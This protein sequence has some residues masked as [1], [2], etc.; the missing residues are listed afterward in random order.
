MFEIKVTLGLDT[1]TKDLLTR[2]LTLVETGKVGGYRAA[3]TTTQVESQ[4]KPENR[5]QRAESPTVD[6]TP[7][8]KAD[9]PTE[10]KKQPQD[11]PK[12]DTGE[13]SYDIEDIRALLAD[14][15][16]NYGIDVVKGLLKKYG[17]ATGKLA[18]VPADKYA[19][20]ADDIAVLGKS[21]A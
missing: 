8:A 21:E 9:A 15:K 14:A 17:A 16:H 13:T 11:E 10:P 7:K 4:K 5:A 18:E 20:L 6:E 12:Q 1:E 3:E 19:A 2:Y